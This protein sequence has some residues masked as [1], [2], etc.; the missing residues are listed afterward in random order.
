MLKPVSL[1]KN[2]SFENIISIICDINKNLKKDILIQYFK[3]IVFDFENKQIPLFSSCFVVSNPHSFDFLRNPVK[4]TG[5]YFSCKN[6]QEGLVAFFSLNIQEVYSYIEKIERFIYDKQEF[7]TKLLK[8]YDKDFA[9][10]SIIDLTNHHKNDFDKDEISKIKSFF[11]YYI[12]L[13]DNNKNNIAVSV[14]MIYSIINVNIIYLKEFF[15]QKVEFELDEETEILTSTEYVI[16]SALNDNIF[17]I[18]EQSDEPI[19]QTE[20]IRKSRYLLF[21]QEKNYLTNTN[22]VFTFEKV[23]SV[24]TEF[25]IEDEDYGNRNFMLAGKGL[26]LKKVM[27]IIVPI[28]NSIFGNV[29][30]KN[31]QKY[32]IKSSNGLYLSYFDWHTK[33]KLVFSDE[34]TKKSEWFI[35]IKNDNKIVI[36]PAGSRQYTWFAIDIPNAVQKHKA[37][38]WIFIKNDSNAQK[39]KL[40]KVKR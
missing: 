32:Y 18:M 31:S 37:P 11:E 4:G 14:L 10:Q 1:S 23:N 13:I 7:V 16:R 30:F 35:D 19:S 28:T 2:P 3:D 26:P 20:K 9:N 17:L 27:N 40:H 36:T 34:K 29:N 22:S 24:N 21:A 5:K 6:E 8:E 39:F 33:A 38:M 15:E 12:Y 25:E